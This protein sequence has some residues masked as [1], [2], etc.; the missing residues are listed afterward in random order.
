M[1]QLTPEDIAVQYSLMMQSVQL[2]NDYVL[3][4]PDF[5]D[6]TEHRQA[7]QRNVT[8]L[9]NMKAKD[10]WTTEDMAPVDAA[11]AAGTVFLQG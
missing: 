6:S 7:I 8:Q 11:I 3:A 2:I 5:M 10:F 9:E 1:E 4:C